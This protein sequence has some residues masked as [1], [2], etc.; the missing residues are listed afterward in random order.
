MGIPA[1]S[2]SAN[3]QE[4]PQDML[5]VFLSFFQEDPKNSMREMLKR[6]WEERT[7]SYKKDLAYELSSL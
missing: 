4:E 2:C 3:H 1:F 7:H 6:H 5:Q